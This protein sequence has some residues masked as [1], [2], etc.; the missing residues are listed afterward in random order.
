MPLIVPVT[1]NKMLLLIKKLITDTE[2]EVGGVCVC[3]FLLTL[4]VCVLCVCVFHYFADTV[5]YISPE[6]CQPLMK[7]RAWFVPCYSWDPEE[8]DLLGRNQT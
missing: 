1:I 4:R 8:L 2:I 6:S 3:V 5:N 7:A